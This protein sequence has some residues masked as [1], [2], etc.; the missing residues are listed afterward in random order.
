MDLSGGPGETRVP[1]GM[2]TDV[3]LLRDAVHCMIREAHRACKGHKIPGWRKHRYLAN[4]VQKSFYSVRTRRQW[5]DTKKVGRYLALCRKLVLRAEASVETLKAKGIP[6]DKV[7]HYLRHAQRQVDQVHRR[8]VKGEVIPH[9]EKVFSIH[10]SHVQ[11]KNKGKAGVQ[12]ELGMMVTSM[13]DQHQFIVQHEVVRKGVDSDMIVQ[14]MEKAKRR[15][16]SLVSCSMDRGFYSPKNRERLDELLELNAMPKKGGRTKEDKEREQAPD[17]VEARRQHPAIESAINNLNQRGLSLIRTH[18]EE[19]FVRTVAL[20]VVATNVHRLGL[21]LR[22]KERR[23]IRWH[24]AR[25]R[26]A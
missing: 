3:H 1:T 18:G 2:P 23:K 12:A 8:L 13:E 16:P 25:K 9:E 22:N 5:R 20:I 10:E 19:G 26:A 17:F 15:N 6:H 21:I 7:L 24:A 4:E 14:F 11:W